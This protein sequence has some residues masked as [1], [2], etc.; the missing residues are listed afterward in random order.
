MYLLLF[1]SMYHLGHLS[2]DGSVADFL[3]MSFIPCHLWCHKSENLTFPSY[4]APRGGHVTQLWP[5]RGQHKS[6]IMF[7]KKFTNK[8][9]RLKPCIF[10][11]SS[12]CLEC[13]HL[14]NTWAAILC[15]YLKAWLRE[16]QMGA[17]TPSS[18][19]A[20]TSNCLHLTLLLLE[21]KPLIA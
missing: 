16:S 11:P 5:V 21:N 9:D 18:Y 13:R 6:A 19:R 3:T 17:L 1:A 20:T 12:S 2:Q 14:S 8:E 7:L 4:L 10:P 15:P